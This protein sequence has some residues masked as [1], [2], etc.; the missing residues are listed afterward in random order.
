MVPNAFRSEIFSLKPVDATGHHS[1]LAVSQNI[2][3]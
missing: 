3:S 2:N 1:V